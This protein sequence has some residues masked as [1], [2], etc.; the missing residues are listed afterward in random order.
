MWHDGTELCVPVQKQVTL[1]T[2]LP[3]SGL[4]MVCSA[5]LLSLTRP[6]PFSLCLSLCK[7]FLC[8]G[9]LITG[10]VRLLLLPEAAQRVCFSL[11]L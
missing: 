10:T 5:L 8:K 7:N 11:G 4:E 6:P 9:I 2:S 3:M 1:R